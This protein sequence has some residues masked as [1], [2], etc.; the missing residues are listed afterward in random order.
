MVIV[1]ALALASL[2]AGE[3]AIPGFGEP[4]VW[5]VIDASSVKGRPAM[6]AWSDE[7]AELYLETVQGDTRESLKLHHYLL[8]PGKAPQSI[9]AQPAW[10][11][12]YWKWKSAKA[13]FGDPLLVIAVDTRQEVLDNLNGS[14]ANKAVYL[15]ETLSGRDLLLA[16]Q[17][18]GTRI[19]HHLLLKGH[20]I[21]EF[22]DEEIVPGYTF[23]WSPQDLGLIAYRSISGRLAVMN[24]AGDTLTAAATKDVLLPAWSDDGASI[25]YLERVGRNKLQVV[26]VRVE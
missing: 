17:T 16:K 6:L 18:G 11:Q 4:A 2:A 13:F 25:A 1:L 20:V 19:T 14:A 21:G 12:A 5:A 26:V 8:H 15:Q 9:D 7:G 23:G 10:A 22:V 3:Q 24:A